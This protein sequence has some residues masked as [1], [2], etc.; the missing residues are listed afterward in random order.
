MKMWRSVDKFELEKYI[1]EK[2][3]GEA[4]EQSKQ[5]GRRKFWIIWC[6]RSQEKCFKKVIF[7]Q[8]LSGAKELSKMKNEKFPLGLETWYDLEMLQE[9]TFNLFLFV[10]SV[11]QLLP[12]M[13]TDVVLTKFIPG[14]FSCRISLICPR[15]IHVLIIWD[16]SMMWTLSMNQYWPFLASS[17]NGNPSHPVSMKHDNGTQHGK[18]DCYGDLFVTRVRQTLLL[19]SVGNH[20]KAPWTLKCI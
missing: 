7:Q 18:P 5:G 17:G 14:C 4:G 10:T 1:W 20:D 19:Y 6:P 15:K 3:D 9:N 16:I 13:T 11:S 8:M 2:V 12:A